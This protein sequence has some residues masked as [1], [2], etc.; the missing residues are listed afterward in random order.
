MEK[1]LLSY[2]LE[3]YD[4]RDFFGLTGNDKTFSVKKEDKKKLRKLWERKHLI[5]LHN[6]IEADNIVM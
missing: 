2:L 6:I 5:S 1:S 3:K 4:N